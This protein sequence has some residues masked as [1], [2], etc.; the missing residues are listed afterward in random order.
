MVANKKEQRDRPDEVTEDVKHLLMNARNP[1]QEKIQMEMVYLQCQ[2]R[3][4]ATSP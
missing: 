3:T 1:E 2:G 4:S